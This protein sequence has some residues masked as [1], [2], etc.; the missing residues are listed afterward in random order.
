MS[1]GWVVDDL[2]L[3]GGQ[4]SVDE[5]GDVIGPGDIEIQTR[6]VF[7]NIGKVLEKA[8]VGWEHVVKLNTYYVCDPDGDVVDFWEK[9]TRVRMQFLR[10]PG[11]AATAVR[12]VGLMYPELVIEADCMAV[13]PR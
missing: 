3:V 11:P 12:V 5:Q 2:V 9:M 10:A 6:E 8:G 7:T 13:R 1:Q 4:I